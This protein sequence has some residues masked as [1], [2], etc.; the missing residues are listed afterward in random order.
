MSMLSRGHLYALGLSNNWG[1]Y[2]VLI[3]ELKR[4]FN[5]QV[6]ELAN[7][8]WRQTQE[9]TD[10]YKPSSGWMY[11]SV[12]M[13]R[14]TTD[15]TKFEIHLTLTRQNGYDVLQSDD[16]WCFGQV[17]EH[18]RDYKYEDA[19]LVVPSEFIEAASFKNDILQ[20]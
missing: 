12:S 5:S 13:K 18:L 10:T 17:P 11:K 16:I 19:V 20:P 15:S 2:Q 4:R 8:W 1:D 7:A 3:G 9:L 14:S 6:G